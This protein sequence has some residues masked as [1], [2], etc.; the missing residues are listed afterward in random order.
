MLRR[1]AAVVLIAG[2]LSVL[3]RRPPKIRLSVRDSAATFELLGV[4]PL[5]T[6]RRSVVVPIESIVGVRVAPRADIVAPPIRFPGTYVPGMLRAGAYGWPG[7]REFWDVRR[8]REY[9]VVDL[10][11]VH[12]Y[13]RLVLERPDAHEMVEELG[14]HMRA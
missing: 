14:T 11:G 10:A 4:E 3:S 5:L 6:L 12:P 13:R 9:L 8:G 7:R 1:L 2:V